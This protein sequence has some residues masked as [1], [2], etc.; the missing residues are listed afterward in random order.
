MLGPRFWH[1]KDLD[2]KQRNWNQVRDARGSQVRGTQEPEPGEGP[3]ALLEACDL[4]LGGDIAGRN[5]V[6]SADHPRDTRSVQKKSS[7]C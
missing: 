3:K 6:G 4:I 7:H 2:V 1:R 5:S